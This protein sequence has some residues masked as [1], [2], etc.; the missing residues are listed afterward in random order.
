[1]RV[2][3]DWVPKR[4]RSWVVA[5][6]GGADSTALLHWLKHHSPDIELR[7]IHVNHQVSAD[8]GN[9]ARRCQRV[10]DE[11][12]VPL[13]VAVV[14]PDS[15]DESALRTA[16]YQALQQSLEREDVLLTA[17]HRD[18]QAETF[19]LRA[20]RGAGSRG[21]AGIPAIRPFGPG[22]LVRPL[23][24]CSHQSLVDYCENHHLE[25]IEDPSNRLDHAD[26]NFIRL[27]VLPTLAARWHDP[28]DQFSRC[29]EQLRQ[30]QQLIDTL[31]NRHL[32]RLTVAPG[33]MSL[34]GLFALDAEQRHQV[35]TLW[36]LKQGLPSI[37][38]TVEH[39]LSDL[40][41]DNNDQSATLQWPGARLCRYRDELHLM[42]PASAAP[43]EAIVSATL[44]DL[45]DLASCCGRLEVLG[46]TD[47]AARYPVTITFSDQLSH[48]SAVLKPAGRH[49]RALK[50]WFQEAGIP[51]WQRPHVPLLMHGSDLIAIADLY[52]EADLQD[53]LDRHKLR[54]R[55][56]TPTRLRSTIG[57]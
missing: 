46:E 32:S 54:L 55:W 47:S 49:R 10:C 9:W 21:L 20:L 30:T 22:W 15:P 52:L 8:A 41:S 3:T 29:T 17:H 53:W 2:A 14:S 40:M 5:F 48:K 35:L 44:P 38:R 7:A 19:L 31:A 18:D 37:P 13:E 11:M 36:C 1:M 56:L 6:S 16:R 25:W 23:L 24:Q 39:R 34:A 26:R 33:V 57:G 45:P 12:G 51:P 27:H 42:A 50:H 28:A 4:A 43:T